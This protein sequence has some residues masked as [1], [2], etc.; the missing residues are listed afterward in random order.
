MA[1]IG[2]LFLVLI[3]SPLSDADEPPELRWCLDD[4][5]HFYDKNTDPQGPT[6][7]ARSNHLDL[8]STKKINLFALIH[9]KLRLTVRL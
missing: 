6:I 1:R 5:W 4:H 7:Q 2:F 8:I 3:Y 9:N